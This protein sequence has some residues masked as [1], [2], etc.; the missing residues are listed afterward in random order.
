MID[1][2][3]D[4]G[5]KVVK[6]DLDFEGLWCF[7]HNYYV[8]EV[9][10]D[11]RCLFDLSL[12]TSRTT[13]LGIGPADGSLAVSFFESIYAGLCEGSDDGAS[14]TESPGVPLLECM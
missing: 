10:N 4:R 9:P 11:P 6:T 13:M 5:R 7:G 2:E 3:E 1:T 14:D 12:S 8:E